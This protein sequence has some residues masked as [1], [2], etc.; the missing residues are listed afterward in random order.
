MNNVM[1][2][3]IISAPNARKNTAV[4]AGTKITKAK[5]A[6]NSKRALVSQQKTQPSMNLLVIKNGNN[7]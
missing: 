3:M 6:K 7:A 2:I 4:H 5:L 1:V